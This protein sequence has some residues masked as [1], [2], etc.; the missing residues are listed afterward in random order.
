MP[1]TPQAPR[2]VAEA[3]ALPEVTRAEIW[4]AP[5]SGL[6]LDGD[7]IALFSDA[8]GRAMTVVAHDGQWKKAEV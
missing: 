1:D 8:D 6:P 7:A 2:T 4:S 5:L 3:R